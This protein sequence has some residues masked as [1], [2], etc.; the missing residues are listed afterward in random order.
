MRFRDRPFSLPPCPQLHF[1]R[2][3][4][5]VGHLVVIVFRILF[6][7]IV[8]WGAVYL[9]IVPGFGITLFLL[10]R[11]EWVRGCYTRRSPSPISVP[12]AFGRA[13]LTVLSDIPPLRKTSMLFIRPTSYPPFPGPEAKTNGCVDTTRVISHCTCMSLSSFSGRF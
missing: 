3:F 13:L 8:K 1:A 5:F 10:V 4:R 11:D 2:G 7:D 6:V 9:I 12:L